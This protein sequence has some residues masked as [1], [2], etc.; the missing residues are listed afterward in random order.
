MK[1]V[2]LEEE[3]GKA[4]VLSSCRGVG[5]L[6]SSWPSLDLDSRVPCTPSH[7]THLILTGVFS[8]SPAVTTLSLEPA[9]SD[10]DTFLH[11]QTKILRQELLFVVLGHCLLQHPSLF[12]NMEIHICILIILLL[13]FGAAFLSL[14]TE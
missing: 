8:N 13:S 10:S 9:N 5:K 3:N 14:D 6:W 2:R 4:V 7:P 1:C 12:Y 11:W